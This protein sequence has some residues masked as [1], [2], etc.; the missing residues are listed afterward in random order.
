MQVRLTL[1]RIETLLKHSK[2]ANAGGRNRLHRADYT[3]G[4]GSPDSKADSWS[5]KR[6]RY[7]SSKTSTAAAWTKHAREYH[8]KSSKASIERLM[9]LILEQGETIQQQL[10]KLR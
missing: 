1:R 7:R 3:N 10:T 4:R 5:G 8:P 2:H 6:K 9:K